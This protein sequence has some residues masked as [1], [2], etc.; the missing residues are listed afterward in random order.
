[1]SV[2][3]SIEDLGPCQRRVHIEVPAPAVDAETARVVN[4]Y[5]RQVR[6]PGFRK[7]KVPSSL[8]QKRFKDEIEREV[9]DRL[10]PRYWKQAEAESALEPLLPPNVEQVELKEGEPLTFVANVEVQPSIELGDVENFDLPEA[11][12]EPTAEET[13]EALSSLRSQVADWIEVERAAARGDLVHLEST[14]VDEEGEPTGESQEVD[15]EV[16]HDNVWE[17]LSLAVT[18]LEAGQETTFTRQEEHGDHSH[19]RHFSVKLAAVK[20]K[21]LPELDDELAKRIGDFESLDALRE[22]IRERLGQE[23]DAAARA[24]REQA[25]LEQ[26]RERHPLELPSGVVEE[27]TRGLLREYA[28]SLSRQG[29][30]IEKA[31]IDWNQMAEEVRPQSERRVHARLVLDS[32]AGEFEVDVEPEELETRLA[33]IARAQG[34]TTTSL[35][36][37]LSQGG[38]LEGLRR[39]MRREKTIARLLGTEP[40]ADSD[41]A[42]D[43]SESEE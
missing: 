29:V 17:E 30:D 26:L 21:D 8:V 24:A 35:R 2:V 43:V 25:V 28:E 14:E 10:V 42:E 37:G 12:T 7:G 9:L 6:L 31:S 11:V 3:S 34:K 16:G 20:E 18:G 15:L 4:E 19:L 32:V 36:Q 33:L 1:M 27:E 41:V 40:K 5:G 13:D 22:Q 38:Q 39:Q 23:K